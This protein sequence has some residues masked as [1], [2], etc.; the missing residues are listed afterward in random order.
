MNYRFDVA[1][2]ASLIALC[3]CS[4]A[5]A[6][7]L[8]GAWASDPNACGKIFAKNGKS[9]AFTKNS[10]VYGS[11]FIAD[12]DQLRGRSGRCRVTSRKESGDTINLLAACA[13]DVMLSNVQFSLVVKDD[14]T[15]V[16]QFP[17]MEGI[18]VQYKRCP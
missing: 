17:G 3:T 10:D 7:D 4:A 9:F 8:T 1:L 5:S 14:N 6:F 12:G 18:T 11:G 15:I 13:S 2:A 16:R